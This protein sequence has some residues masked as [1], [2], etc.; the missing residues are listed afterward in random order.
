M[1]SGRSVAEFEEMIISSNCMRSKIPI[2]SAL[3]MRMIPLVA[4]DLEE[5]RGGVLKGSMART[6]CGGF[7]VGVWFSFIYV[8]T[9]ALNKAG[10]RSAIERLIRSSRG[11]NGNAVRD[12][13]SVQIGS[14]KL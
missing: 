14:V 1:S 4:D 13:M 7:L 8:P 11:I 2:S 12:Q 6:Y 5:R 9:K 10:G 3:E